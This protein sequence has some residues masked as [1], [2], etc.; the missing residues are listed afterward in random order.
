VFS[1]FFFERGFFIADFWQIFLIS[2]MLLGLFILGF[3]GH[4]GPSV[5]RN[6][7]KKLHI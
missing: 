3:K 6:S 2:Q 4:L 1:R 5:G 7:T